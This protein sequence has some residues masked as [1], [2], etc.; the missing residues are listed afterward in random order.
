MSAVNVNDFKNAVQAKTDR[1]VS[2]FLQ[3]IYNDLAEARYFGNIKPVQVWGMYKRGQKPTVDNEILQGA[4]E[5]V[6]VHLATEGYIP[7]FRIDREN[8]V[9]SW[10]IKLDTESDSILWNIVVLVMVVI[11]GLVMWFNYSADTV[12]LSD[13]FSNFFHD[14]M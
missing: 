12:N 5:R 6:K 2:E 1:C 10:S 4:W 14:L 8:N 9:F 11:T 13:A 7:K 3:V